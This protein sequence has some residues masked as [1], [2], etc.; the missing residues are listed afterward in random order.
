MNLETLTS[1]NHCGLSQ[2]GQCSGWNVRKGMKRHFSSSSEHPR[3]NL[4]PHPPY[5]GRHAE[6][7]PVGQLPFPLPR[8]QLPHCL[9]WPSDKELRWNYSS[10]LGLLLEMIRKQ[11]LK[12]FPV[13]MC[14]AE[15]C[16]ETELQGCWTKA[17]NR[18]SENVKTYLGSLSQG[19]VLSTL[20][21][22]PKVR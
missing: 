1:V 22:S 2:W 21:L 14:S 11:T 7:L 8:Q 3:K 15:E 10:M 19:M 4:D 9:S 17:L 18:K 13:H 20:V 12:N 6:Y 16:W 5:S